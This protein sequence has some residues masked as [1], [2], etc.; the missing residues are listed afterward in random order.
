MLEVCYQSLNDYSYIQ[1]LFHIDSIILKKKPH[2]YILT[3]I[4]TIFAAW[5]IHLKYKFSKK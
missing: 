4:F 3:I 2:Y 5:L 1:I